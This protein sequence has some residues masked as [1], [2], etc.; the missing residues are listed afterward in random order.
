MADDQIILCG[1]TIG[2][3]NGLIGKL[4]EVSDIGA[5]RRAVD[6]SFSGASW[7][8]VILSCI[9][10]LTPFTATIAFE[11][12]ADWKTG[13][14]AQLETLTITWAIPEN[15]TTAATLSFKAGLTRFTIRGSNEERVVA[16]VT[17]TPSGE[18]T[19]TSGT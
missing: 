17:I 19:L 16:T 13:I 7:A 10:R 2:F 9:A 1:T 14:K 3:Q 8:E 4:L 11:P 12:N 6:A 18:P 15:G 5:E